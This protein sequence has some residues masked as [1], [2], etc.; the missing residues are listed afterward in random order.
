MHHPLR[1]LLYIEWMLFTLVTAAEVLPATFRSPNKPIWVSFAALFLLA[2]MGLRLPQK[3]LLIKLLYTITEISVIWVAIFWGGLRLFSLLYIVL[4]IRSYLIFARRYRLWITGGAF[5]LFLISLKIRLDQF[6]PPRQPRL[7]E[8]EMIFFWGLV[9]FFGVVLIFLQ[10]LLDTIWSEKQ[11]KEELATAN[12]QVRRYAMRVEDLATLQ[13]RN[14]IAREIHDS[15]GHSLTALNLHLEMAI[16]LAQS[17]PDRARDILLEAKRLGAL[18]LQEVRQSVSTLRADPLQG[19]PLG[20]AIEQ[21]ATN[22]ETTTH[23]RP[24]C[25]ID[26]PLHL[27]REVATTIYRLVQESLTNITKYA[28]ASQVEINIQTQGNSLEL[29]ITDNGCGFEPSKNTTGFGLQGMQERVLSVRG[30]FQIL[31]APDRGCQVIA[32]IPLE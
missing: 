11:A 24:E 7:P 1:L 5:V 9:L 19:V 8:R 31:S 27:S 6:P 25:I 2:L 17:Q 14:R 3:G 18:S 29:Q 20:N 10:L 28:R 12:Q 4:I 30:Q 21:L 15:L 26:L 22:F 13:E 16:K 23:I 32:K